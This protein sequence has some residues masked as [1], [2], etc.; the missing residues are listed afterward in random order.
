M[1][2]DVVK[3][4]LV[5]DM[6]GPVTVGMVLLVSRRNRRELMQVNEFEHWHRRIVRWFET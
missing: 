5:T 3:T 2:S 6:C 4:T 1:R